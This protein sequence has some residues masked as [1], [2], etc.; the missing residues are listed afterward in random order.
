MTHLYEV[1]SY[2]DTTV[3]HWHR[4]LAEAHA[5]AKLSTDRPAASIT[6]R[7][8]PNDQAVFCGL[9]NGIRPEGKALRRWKLTPKGGLREVPADGHELSDDRVE[10]RPTRARKDK[11]EPTAPPHLDPAAF[12]ADLE[13]K[14][15]A[16][17]GA[18]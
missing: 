11:P 2:E 6:L 9:F 3:P 8:Y 7:D 12:W 4:T 18:A 1:H 17:K 14:S 13:A 15:A 10:V 16:R 5:D